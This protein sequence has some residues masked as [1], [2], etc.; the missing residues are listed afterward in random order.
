MRILS[1][2]FRSRKLCRTSHLVWFFLTKSSKNCQK[3]NGRDAGM[4]DERRQEIYQSK[5]NKTIL[6]SSVRN[7]NTG[8]IFNI[9]ELLLIFNLL[10]DWMFCHLFFSRLRTSIKVQFQIIGL[11]PGWF[12]YL[13]LPFSSSPS[14]LSYFL[15]KT[16]FTSF[17]S[18][19]PYLHPLVSRGEPGSVAVTFRS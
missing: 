11:Q 4:V 7:V 6:Q 1:T 10:W 15:F 17:A 16:L 12:S 3:L 2:K 14:L 9:K 8:W 5:N 13:F 19:I 18:P